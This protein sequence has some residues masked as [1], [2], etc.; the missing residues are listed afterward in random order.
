MISP[1][2]DIIPSCLRRIE[3]GKQVRVLFACES[4][5]R[6]WGFESKDS[7]WDVRYIYLGRD[8]TYHTVFPQ[9]DVIEN[10]ELPWQ[11]DPLLDFAGWD[12]PE[13]PPDDES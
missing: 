4:G 7:D 10:H 9:R 1:A 8:R 5:S 11:T 2:A 13:A 6:A 12:L 3:H